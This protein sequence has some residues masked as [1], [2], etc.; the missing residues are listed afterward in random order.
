MIDKEIE[1]KIIAQTK[2]E[3]KYIAHNEHAR[4]FNLYS[5][6]YALDFYFMIFKLETIKTLDDYKTRMEIY[7]FNKNGVMFPTLKKVTENKTFYNAMQLIK[8]YSRLEA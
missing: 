1:K 6:P 4:D 8:H 2:A 7:S 3:L 5:N